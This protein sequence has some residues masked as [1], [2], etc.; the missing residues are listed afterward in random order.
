MAGIL[1]VDDDDL[2]RGVMKRILD[3]GNHTI[4]QADNGREALQVVLTAP[5]DLVITDILMP[6]RDG[7][8]VIAELRGTHPW[9][10]VLA[11]SGGGDLHDFDVLSL[12][13]EVGAH[14]A[15]QKPFSISDLLKAVNDL[16][17]RPM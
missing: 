9:V 15:I 16:L 1:I 17:A 7:L 2:T 10:K 4:F 11:Y 5:I 8:D 6:E 12:A 3:I 14:A 13:K